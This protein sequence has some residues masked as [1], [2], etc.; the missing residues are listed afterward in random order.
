MEGERLMAILFSFGGAT[1]TSETAVLLG[2]TVL[3]A[4]TVTLVEEVTAG[5]VNSPL[6]EIVPALACQR[7]DRV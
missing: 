7:M 2:S 4:T 3:V 5:A 1:V 6:S